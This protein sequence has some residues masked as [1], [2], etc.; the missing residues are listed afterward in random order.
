M[1][2]HGAKPSLSSGVH[3]MA[4]PTNRHKTSSGLVRIN[5][6]EILGIDPGA[7]RDE[8]DA[9]RDRIEAKYA[10]LTGCDNWV[11]QA[12][13]DAHQTLQN[14]PEGTV[15]G[16]KPLTLTGT[17]PLQ[18]E[19]TYFILVNVLDIFMTYLLLNLGAV[20]ANPIANYFIGRWGFAGMIVFKLVIVAAVCVISQVVATRNMRYARGL[21]WIGIA[22]VGCVVVY[23]LRL[24]TGQML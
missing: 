21:L 4:S 12:I 1:S 8:I 20:E 9:A 10:R 16:A 13:R 15:D 24:L 22:V 5:A 2:C 7:S 14:A 11:R 23:S 3:T 19:T 18:N 17:L 6:H